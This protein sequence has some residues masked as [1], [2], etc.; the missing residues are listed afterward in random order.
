M[1]SAGLLLARERSIGRVHCCPHHHLVQHGWLHS[2]VSSKRSS[3]VG[4]Y[5][6]PV[7]L[8]PSTEFGIELILTR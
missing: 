8:S 6:I 4:V 2:S 3:F 5:F 7:P 1:G